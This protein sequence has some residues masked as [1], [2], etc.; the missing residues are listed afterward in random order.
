[1]SSN[2]SSTGFYNFTFFFYLGFDFIKSGLEAIVWK[3][4]FDL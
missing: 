1:M 4:Q 3:I 2:E